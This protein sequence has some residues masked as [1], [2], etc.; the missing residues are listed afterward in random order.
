MYIYIYIVTSLHALNINI[1]QAQI[2]DLW[3]TTPRR[4]I[5]PF[6]SFEEKYCSVFGMNET[7]LGRYSTDRKGEN[8]DYIGCL[9]GF[10]PIKVMK[11]ED[12]LNTVDLP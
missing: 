8:F 3:V 11:W 10:W 7:S 12:I 9:Q 2:I 5:S 6:R 4:I 1:V